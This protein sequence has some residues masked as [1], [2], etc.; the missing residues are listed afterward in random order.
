[1]TM[2]GDSFEGFLRRRQISRRSFLKFCGVMA[3]TLALPADYTSQ[4]ATALAAAPRLPIVWMEFQDC[5]GDTESF[6]RAGSRADPI[7]AGVTDPSL[8]ALLLDYLSVDYHE[9]LMT[10]AGFQA[11]KSLDDTLQKF[12]NQFVLV[13]EGSI[14][15]A[16]NGAY[17]TIAGETALSSLRRVSALARATIAL[18]TCAYDGGLAAAAP[19][20]TGATGVR[21]AVPGLAN[22]INLPGCPANVVNLTASLVYFLTF[23]RWPDLDSARRPYFAYGSEIHEECE[24]RDFYE[25]GQFVLA[26]GDAGHRQGWC[27]FRMGCKG[28]ATRSNC[29]Q[30]KW[31]DGTNWPIG[32]GHGCVGCTSDRFW[33]RLMPAYQPLPGD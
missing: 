12:A 9:T 33:D 2:S 16:L 13:V 3:A 6:L 21:G 11:R 24:R 28:P 17:C 23:Q 26:W 5:T 20:P 14:P 29:N 18:G 31:N 8:T 15:A 19:N 25:R 1:M 30:V 22:L 4:I 27:L 7:Q 10:P 32:A